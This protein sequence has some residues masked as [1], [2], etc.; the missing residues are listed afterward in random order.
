MLQR[1]FRAVSCLFCIIGAFFFLCAALV[2]IMGHGPDRLGFL[3]LLL[4]LAVGASGLGWMLWYIAG[5]LKIAPLEELCRH[6][7]DRP[8]SLTSQMARSGNPV[9]PVFWTR[10]S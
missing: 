1:A 6:P 3:A 7:L 5:P 9:L 10:R 4:P 2:G 8:N